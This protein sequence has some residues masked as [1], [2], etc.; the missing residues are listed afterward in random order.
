MRMKEAYP[1]DFR[2]R[3]YYQVPPQSDA[4]KKICELACTEPQFDICNIDMVNIKFGGVDK[5]VR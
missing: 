4:M 3:L 2:L 5:P 1:S